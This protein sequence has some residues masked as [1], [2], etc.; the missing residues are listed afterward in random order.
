MRGLDA[1]DS[2]QLSGGL[3]NGEHL[4]AAGGGRTAGWRS[5]MK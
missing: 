1:R 2:R 5:L 4:G 3:Q